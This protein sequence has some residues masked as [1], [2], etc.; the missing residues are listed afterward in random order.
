MSTW[1]L[2]CPSGNVIKIHHKD[3]KLSKMDLDHPTFDDDELRNICNLLQVFR[4]K[5]I[6]DSSNFDDDFKFEIVVK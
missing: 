4:S 1:K 3:W 5:N 2:T 6:P